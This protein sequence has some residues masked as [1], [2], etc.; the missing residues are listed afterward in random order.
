MTDKKPIDDLLDGLKKGMEQGA[1]REKLR[2]LLSSQ[3]QKLNVVSREEFDAQSEV[4][5]RTR[6]LLEQL[7]Q[8]LE[9]LKNPPQ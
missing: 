2:S 7:E 6:Q 1:P 3:L 5:A 8:E 9:G 4:L